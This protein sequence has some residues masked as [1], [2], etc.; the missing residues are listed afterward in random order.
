MLRTAL[1]C[2]FVTAGAGSA[3]AVNPPAE[4]AA[5]LVLHSTLSSVTGENSGIAAPIAEVKP[6]ET[7]TITGA[8]IKRV[9]SVENLRVVLTI[10]DNDAAMPGYRSVLATDQEIRAGGLHVR[11]PDLPE[12]TN[13]VFQVKVFHLGQ[14]APEICDAGT[15]RIG[16]VTPRKVGSIL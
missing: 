3:F 9:H 14:E 5:G 8:C 2:V 7:F 1:I 10:A 15:I 4:N 11:V 12:A 13:R 6:G 16:A